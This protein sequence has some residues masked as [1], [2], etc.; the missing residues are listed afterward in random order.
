MSS[1]KTEA[2]QL[3]KD[4]T[5]EH[6]LPQSWQEHWPL[7][8]E[9]LSSL[10]AKLAGEAERNALLHSI[11]N[12]TLVTQSFNS[13]LSNSGWV[14]KK[15]EIWNT[16]KLNLNRYFATPEANVWDEEAIRKRSRKLFQQIVSIWPAGAAVEEPAAA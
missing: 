10:E 16:S 7:S 8:P 12:L 11:G 5:L 13:S 14:V 1:S 9:A 2:L 6:L 4:L 3:P 15:E